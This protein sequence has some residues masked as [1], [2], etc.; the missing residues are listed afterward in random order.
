MDNNCEIVLNNIKEIL[1]NVIM[2]YFTDETICFLDNFRSLSVDKQLELFNEFLNN[3]DECR[4]ANIK[5]LNEQI[6]E[7]KGHEYSKWYEKISFRN[8]NGST[9]RN[10]I[11]CRKCK[12]CGNIDFTFVKPK[13]FNIH[14][15]NSKKLIKTK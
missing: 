5:M 6:C 14:K 1:N 4:N 13:E 7:K 9:F 2:H 10:K 3:V 8:Y 12:K 11:W 15:E